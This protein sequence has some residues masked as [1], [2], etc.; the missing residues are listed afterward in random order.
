MVELSGNILNEMKIKIVW[1]YF[2]YILYLVCEFAL[3]VASKCTYLL[4]LV[5]NIS[6][7]Q[8]FDIIEIGLNYFNN[9]LISIYWINSIIQ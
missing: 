3:D 6:I 5:F 4:K 8:Y 9:S 2:S 1:C 7:V